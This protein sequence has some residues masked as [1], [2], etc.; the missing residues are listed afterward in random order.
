MQFLEK[1]EREIN[2][3]CYVVLIEEIK[4]AYCFLTGH[5]SHNILVFITFFS[6]GRCADLTF[7]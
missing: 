3:T 5:P 7:A 4:I 6:S 1:T 2:I